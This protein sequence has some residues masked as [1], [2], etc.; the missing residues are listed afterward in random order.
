MCRASTSILLIL[1]LGGMV[2]LAATFTPVPSPQPGE[3]PGCEKMAAAHDHPAMKDME[4]CRTHN[5]AASKD[6]QDAISCCAGMEGKGAMA[7]GHEKDAKAT[8]KEGKAASCCAG[9][10]CGEGK[11]MNCCAAKKGDPATGC[12]GGNSCGKH[13]HAEDAAPGN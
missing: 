12:C 7:C 8:A 9:A 11:E 3:M 2:A 5:D 6:S 10:K 13:E 4:G 1:L